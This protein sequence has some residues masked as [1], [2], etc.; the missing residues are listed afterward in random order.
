ME[1][2]KETENIFDSSG[3]KRSRVGFVLYSAFDYFISLL[4]TDAFLAKLLLNMGFS[5][6]LIGVVSSIVG[7][8][9]FFQIATI[10]L[11]QKIRSLKAF[12][13]VTIESSYL[14]FISLYLLPFSPF[15]SYAK[16]LTVIVFILLARFCY[17]VVAPFTIK[18]GYTF[19]D[20]KK[21][22]AFVAKNEII[23]IIGGMVFTIFVG[24]MVDYYESINNI[25][26]GFVFVCVS[27]LVLSILSLLSLLNI[28]D[29]KSRKE[30]SEPLKNCLK[31]IVCNK[32][33]IAL[34]IL[35]AIAAV[36]GYLTVPFMGTYKTKELMFSV[37]IVQVINAAA[38]ICRAFASRLF[39]KISDKISFA[40]SIEIG[41]FISAVAFALSIFAT[42]KTRWLNIIF[43]V[44]YTASLAGTGTNSSIMLYNFVDKKYFSQAL[45]LQNIVIG[46]VVI[47]TSLVASRILG[48]IQANGNTVFGIHMYA[49]QFLSAISLVLAVVSTLFVRFAFCGKKELKN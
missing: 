37:G 36:S 43:T 34:M 3:Y 42:P 26:G 31:N 44:L 14:F 9:S 40:K 18:W 19:V 48:A 20:P 23:A 7:A 17:S 33:C 35:N 12:S 1:T 47:G 24:F 15:G 46:A 39:G 22:G 25:K 38:T 32:G 13:I 10:L 45:A 49:Q 28:S 2:V 30:Q 16:Q 11:A 4:V 21:R 8:A 27:G 5:D 29:V 41:Y 6:T